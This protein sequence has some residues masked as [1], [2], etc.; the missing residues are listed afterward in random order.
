MI[1]FLRVYANEVGALIPPGEIVLDMGRYREPPGDVSR[2]ERTPDEPGAGI[3]PADRLVTGF[4]PF[5]GGVQ[6]DARRI[7]R[8]LAGSK[9]AGSPSSMAGRLWR[10]ARGQGET[11]FY[12]VTNRR[13]LLLAARGAGPQ[14]PF[15][16]AWEV[17]RSSVVVAAR[18]GRFLQAGRVEV[19][20]SDGSA[21]A[22]T[23]GTFSAARARTL[24]AA[25]TA[26]LTSMGE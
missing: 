21:K 8:F 20:F 16:V 5:A 13:L 19:G 15:R 26:P 25:L 10:A 1:D 12:A 2:L 23:T 9:G 18:H 11:F 24:V 4:D 17:P 3:P 6:T 22:W 14:R 7:D